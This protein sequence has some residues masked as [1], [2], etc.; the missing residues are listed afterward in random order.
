MLT[1]RTIEEV[2]ERLISQFHPLKII[3]FGSRSRGAGTEASDLDLLVVVKGD[4]SKRAQAAAMYRAL[5]GLDAAADIVVVT[6]EEFEK[7]RNV[8]GTIIR[9]A[10]RE[11][12]VLYERTP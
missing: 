8:V 5:R 12:R 11:G 3:L 2:C 6:A 10:D 9:P 7:Y 4:G 1:E